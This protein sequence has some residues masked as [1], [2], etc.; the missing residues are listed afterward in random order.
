MKSCVSAQAD[1]VEMFKIM[2]EDKGLAIELVL[3]S[4]DQRARIGPQVFRR[5]LE[6]LIWNAIKYTAGT[7]GP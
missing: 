2:A 4:D 3:R 6:N 5:I 7:E 1:T